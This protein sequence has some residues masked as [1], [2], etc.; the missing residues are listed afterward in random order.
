M[1]ISRWW[2]EQIVVNPYKGILRS[3]KKEWLVDKHW[4]LDEAQNNYAQWK[5]P[6]KKDYIPYDPVYIYKML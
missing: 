5:N 2:D 4:P 1:S 3:N 6:A